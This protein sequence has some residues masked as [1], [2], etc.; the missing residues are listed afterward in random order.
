MGDL[1][2]FGPIFMLGMT[3]RWQGEGV[4]FCCVCVGVSLCLCLF[5]SGSHVQTA[6]FKNYEFF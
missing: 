4:R 5:S 3:M 6:N 2:Y 1:A